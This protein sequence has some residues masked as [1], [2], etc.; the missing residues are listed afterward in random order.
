[1]NDEKAIK[2]DFY[3]DMF[4]FSIFWERLKTKT[5]NKS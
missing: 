5:N 1:M 3:C 2:N 4:N